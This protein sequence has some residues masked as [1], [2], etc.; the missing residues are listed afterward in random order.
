MNHKYVKYFFI[1]GYCMKD[2]RIVN[3]L[4]K[5]R[6]TDLLVLAFENCNGE[7]VETESRASRRRRH[8]HAHEPNAIS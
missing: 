3:I 7:H 2:T 5:I 4:S 6:M 1:A 8:R